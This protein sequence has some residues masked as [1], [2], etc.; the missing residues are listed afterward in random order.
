MIMGSFRRYP[1]KLPMI[2]SGL[3]GI[4]VGQSG[5]EGSERAGSA[6]EC[7]GLVPWSEAGLDGSHATARAGPLMRSKRI[8]RPFREP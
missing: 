2:M 3:G 7:M 4:V 5:R 6:V 1:S 8:T